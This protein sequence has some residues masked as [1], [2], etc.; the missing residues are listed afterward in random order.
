MPEV[1]TIYGLLMRF[2]AERQRLW[3]VSQSGPTAGPLQE[4]P[5]RDISADELARRVNGFANFIATDGVI[6]GIQS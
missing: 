4:Y 6:T 2:N 5:Y 1:A 3:L